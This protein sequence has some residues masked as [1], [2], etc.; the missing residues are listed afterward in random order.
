[1]LTHG[2]DAL[3]SLNADEVPGELV[4]AWSSLRTGG[5]LYGFEE[6]VAWLPQRLLETLESLGGQS[7]GGCCACEM[8]D[9]CGCCWVYAQSL[10]GRHLRVFVLQ[11]C[12]LP[13][14]SPLLPPL[15]CVCRPLAQESRPPTVRGTC[16]T[17][18]AG[19]SSRLCS[20]CPRTSAP[21]L[22]CSSWLRTCIRGSAP[23]TTRSTA[24]V[25]SCLTLTTSPSRVRLA[26]GRASAQ[27]ER[28][29]SVSQPATRK[30]AFPGRAFQTLGREPEGCVGP[31]LHCTR[32]SGGAVHRWVLRV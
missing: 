12:S 15:L 2:A 17:R 14:P 32:V 13:T 8:G 5:G 4:P 24:T 10:D 11:I 16:A 18:S 28:Q 6:L 27:S 20:M 3:L 21:S 22:Q 29:G 23:R 25:F 26:V 7:N 19:A 1:M 9:G 30:S 31:P